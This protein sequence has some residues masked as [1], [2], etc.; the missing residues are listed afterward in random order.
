MLRLVLL[1]VLAA[2]TWIY[3]P[4]TRVYAADAARPVLR[5]VFRW[6]TKQEMTSI[7]HE[8]E[9]AE[10][11]GFGRLPDARRFKTWLDQTFTGDATVDS[12]G[13]PYSLTVAKDSFTVVSWGPDALPNTS[14]DIHIARR[15]ASLSR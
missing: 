8:L 12:W 6:Q 5:P 11:E 10:R 2:C 15:R 1:V 9:L 13:M 3:F 4:E 7:A 14:D